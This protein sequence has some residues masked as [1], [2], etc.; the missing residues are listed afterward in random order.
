MRAH[1]ASNGRE[2]NTRE[3]MSP[4]G[5][6]TGDCALY[7]RTHI[8]DTYLLPT[9][10]KKVHEKA[11]KTRKMRSPRDRQSSPPLCT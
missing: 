3:A 7:T 4:C 6:D 1:A 9:I 5:R 10:Q 2:K 8:L 11:F